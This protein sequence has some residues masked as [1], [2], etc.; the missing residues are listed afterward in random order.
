M[1]WRDM[2]SL[3]VRGELEWFRPSRYLVSNS[4]ST[5]EFSTVRSTALV[6]VKSEY[7]VNGVSS[8][9]ILFDD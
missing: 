2:V 5:V 3:G 9:E 7:L 8:R 6:V 4:T 1:I